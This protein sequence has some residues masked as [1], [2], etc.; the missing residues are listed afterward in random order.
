MWLSKKKAILHIQKYKAS[1]FESA[2]L[3]GFLQKFQFQILAS[4]RIKNRMSGM[5]C[6]VG[7]VKIWRQ[8]QP[9]VSLEAAQPGLLQPKNLNS[10]PFAYEGRSCDF[11]QS[12]G[13][14]IVR[15]ISHLFWSAVWS[16]KIHIFPLHVVKI[17]VILKI[18]S[19]MFVGFICWLDTFQDF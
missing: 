7:L 8:Q 3:Q 2:I 6:D 10:I 17:L 18:V 13:R 19:V 12:L 9:I 14:P 11:V 5:H 4:C 1:I 16:L 15:S